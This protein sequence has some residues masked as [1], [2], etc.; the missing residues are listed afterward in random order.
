[1]VEEFLNFDT[2]MG[3]GR[4]GLQASLPHRKYVKKNKLEKIYNKNFWEELI[5]YFY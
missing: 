2:K 4:G 1:V 5:A 3:F